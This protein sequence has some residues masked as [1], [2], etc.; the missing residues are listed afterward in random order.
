[1]LFW[2]LIKPS[3]FNNQVVH[4]KDSL[5]MLGEYQTRVAEIPSTDR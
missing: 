5:K 2:I 3:D 1:M 4:K